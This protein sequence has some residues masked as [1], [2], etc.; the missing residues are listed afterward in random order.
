MATNAAVTDYPLWERYL[1]I[2]LGAPQNPA[3]LEALNNWAR[4]EGMPGDTNN[5]LAITD[6]NNWYGTPGGDPAGALANG[7]WNYESNGTTPLVVTFATQAQGI[8]ALVKFLNAGHTD[9]I[10]ALR[11]PKATVESIGAAVEADK[12]WGGDGNKII[13]LAGGNPSVYKDNGTGTQGPSTIYKNGP[14]GSLTFSQCNPND[15]LLGENGVSV[16]GYTVVP[17][18]HLFNA[19]QLKAVVAGLTIGL[20]VS[21]LGLGVT[22][23]ALNSKTVSGVSSDIS[24]TYKKAKKVFL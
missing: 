2:A 14:T 18:V 1:L 20:G 8:S 13:E 9:I 15:S 4:A 5:W 11:D 10:E 3:Q 21:I 16:L 24:N 12:G 19:C 23:I 7:V 6:P 22:L 17:G